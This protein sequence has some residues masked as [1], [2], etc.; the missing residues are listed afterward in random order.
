MNKG[1]TCKKCQKYHEFP[2][3]VYAH[4][5]IDLVHTCDCGNKVKLRNGRVK[6]LT[7]ES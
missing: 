7:K 5:N 2:A 1:Y 6:Q 4:M 3:Y